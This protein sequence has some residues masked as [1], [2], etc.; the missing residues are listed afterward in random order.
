MDWQEQTTSWDYNGQ[1]RLSGT[2][3]DIVTILHRLDA[4]QQFMTIEGMRGTWRMVGI[5]TFLSSYKLS[6]TMAHIASPQPVAVPKYAFSHSMVRP[7][8]AGLRQSLCRKMHGFFHRA[9][10]KGKQE[11][12]VCWLRKCSLY[13]LRRPLRRPLRTWASYNSSHLCT[14]SL[15]IAVLLSWL[16]KGHC[17]WL[18]Q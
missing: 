2:M 8:P 1:A 6:G 4:W 5:R 10:L 13:A 11:G 7:L 12:C 17:K 18:E 16:C 3:A 9:E 15:S 14:T